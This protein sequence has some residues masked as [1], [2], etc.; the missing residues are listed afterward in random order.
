MSPRFIAS[1]GVLSAL[2]YVGS[3]LLLAIPN[4]TLSIM[5]VFFAGFY[6]GVRGGLLVG[7][8]GSILIS[9]LNPYGIVQLPILASQVVSY[10]LI[11]ALG[12]VIAPLLAGKETWLY[13]VWLGLLGIVTALIYQLSVSV[14]DALVFG[15][16]WARLAASGIFA[17]VTIIGN[18]IFFV[19]L[20]PIL[21]KLKKVAIFRTD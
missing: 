18:V 11:G 13:L 14:V 21:A 4:V 17:L 2:A 9:L 6:L 15:P 12:G 20:F 19:I 1:V 5:L 10:G 8:I 16:F 3:F 7:F